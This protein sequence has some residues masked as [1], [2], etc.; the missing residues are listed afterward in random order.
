ML[1]V[2]HPSGEGSGSPK[3]EGMKPQRRAIEGLDQ[4]I[5][6]FR[7]ALVAELANPYLAYGERKR[8]IKDKAGRQWDMPWSR[9]TTI[10]EATI[11]HWLEL[12]RQYGSEGLR[13][14]RRADCGTSR[15]VSAEAAQALVDLLK[16]EPEL[17]ARS[18]WNKLMAE[19]TITRTV[20]SSTLSRLVTAQGMRRE[21]RLQ[22]VHQEKNLKFDFYHP[23]E[24]VQADCM[25]GP[26]IPGSKG[27][28]VKAILLA[29][30]DDATRRIVYAEFTNSEHSLAFEKGIRHI[31][32]AHGRIGRLY[33]DN[34]S[35]FVSLQTSRILNTLQIHLIHSTPHRPQGRGK[36]ERFF[37][38]VRDCFLRPLEVAS[39][40]G[41]DDLNL[42]F[43]TWL[44]AEYHRNPHHGLGG[45]T[46]LEVW[47]D[48]V[49]LI[50]HVE[51]PESLEQ[52]FQHE[53]C[54][55]VAKDQ[56]VTVGGVLYEVPSVLIGKKVTLRYDPHRPRLQVEAWHEGKHYGSCRILDRY[57]NTRV[58]RSDSRKG[59]IVEDSP[60]T[61]PS[62]QAGLVAAGLRRNH[63]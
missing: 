20:S 35:T 59:A 45:Q 3:E 36:I 29:F 44:E 16:K 6:D 8:L 5:M 17:T 53:C 50:K 21:E 24:C 26:Q 23:L 55:R 40:T 15:A 62:V 63:V 61:L 33:V 25:H 31:L 58:K 46:P 57:A 48:K 30:I 14:K 22:A 7:Q 13:P 34:G 39:I 9:K 1:G 42:R 37:R 51:A 2:Q 11:T 18:A 19:G 60:G 49:R 28:L 54:R 27:T 43:R 10:T 56:T 41:F 4:T 32:L 47:A 52:V 38:T 12:Y